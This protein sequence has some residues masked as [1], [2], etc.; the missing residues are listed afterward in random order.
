MT[1][2]GEEK[3]KKA[4]SMLYNRVISECI[5]DLYVMNKII[6]AKAKVVSTILDNGMSIAKKKATHWS[7][8]TNVKGF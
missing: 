4:A 8:F 6:Y 1:N 7:E 5:C 2:Q 3:K